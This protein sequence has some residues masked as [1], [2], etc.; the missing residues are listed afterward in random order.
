MPFRD[1]QT[2]TKIF[3]ATLLPLSFLLILGWLNVTGI[4][5]MQATERWVRHTNGV[6]NDSSKIVNSAVDM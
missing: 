5:D 2:R 3:I 6:L 1:I 4:E